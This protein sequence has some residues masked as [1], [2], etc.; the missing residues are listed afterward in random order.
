MSRLPKYH[1]EE[2]L[3][4][5]NGELAT[6]LA[7]QRC[8]Q[9]DRTKVHLFAIGAPGGRQFGLVVGDLYAA[10][11]SDPAKQSRILLERCHLPEIPGVEPCEDYY[12]GARATQADSR[13]APPNQ[14]SCL[15]ADAAALKELLRWYAGSAVSPSP[16]PTGDLTALEQAKVEKAAQDA[17]FDISPV[18]EGAWS[19]FRSTLFQGLVGVAVKDGSSYKVGMSDT[20]W[21]TKAAAD[22]DHVASLQEGP[23]PVLVEDVRAFEALHQLLMRA[24]ALGRVVGEAPAEEF[25]TCSTDLPKSTEAERLVVQRVGQDIFR[26]ALIEYWQGRCAVTG[27]DVVPLLRASHIKPW[28][29]CETDAERLDVFN[30]LLLAPHLDALFDGGWVTFLDS[31]DIQISATLN[32]ANRTLLGISGSEVISGLTDRHKSYLEWHRDHRFRY[33]Q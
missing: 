31:G 28:A 16:K 21:G 8:N 12:N 30:G 33:F 22:C 32:S 19:V 29:D 18:Q 24:A 1:C 5:I 4:V 17:G 26:R 9:L 20:R 14:S 15:V 11:G 27:M 3:A 10:K 25:K 2:A 6:E 13:L 23:W 7:I